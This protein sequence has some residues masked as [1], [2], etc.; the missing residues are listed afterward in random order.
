MYN[1]LKQTILNDWNTMRIVRAVLSIIIISEAVSMHDLA[2]GIF[3]GVFMGMAV[4]N[5]G[6]CRGS[7]S[8]NS[9]NNTS[10]NEKDKI[11]FEE[12]K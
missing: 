7:C 2:L 11:E 3:G 9:T 12:I 10:V 6:C 1:T 4:F 5:T 8:V